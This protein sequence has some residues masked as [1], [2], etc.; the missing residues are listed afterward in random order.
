[1]EMWELCFEA[2]NDCFCQLEER[3]LSNDSAPPDA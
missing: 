2:L 1:M 3:V